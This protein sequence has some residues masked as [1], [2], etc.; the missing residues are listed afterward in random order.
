MRERDA[1]I[2]CLPH[3]PNWHVQG[4]GIELATFQFSGPNSRTIFSNVN[5]ILSL[6]C[7]QGLLI[8]LE[9]KPEP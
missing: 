4:L 6:N 1:S 3:A 2:G 7:L 9:L 8:I 5:R